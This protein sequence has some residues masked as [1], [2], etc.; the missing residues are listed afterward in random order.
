[1]N[2]PQ[3]TA[4][5]RGAIEALIRQGLNRSR[6]AEKVGVHRSTMSREINERSS[7]EGYRAGFAQEH[8][9]RERA[10][11][12]QEKKM[13]QPKRQA[14]VTSKLQEGWS[15]EQI[16]GRI[17]LEGRTDLYVCKETIYVWLFSDE[18]AYE[19]EKFYQYLRLGRKKRKQQWGRGRHRSKIPNRVSIHERPPIVAERI[20]FGHFEGDSVIYPHKYA[21]NTLNELLTGLVIFTKLRQ[22][23]AALTAQA[24]SQR[25]DFWQAKTVTLDNGSEFTQHEQVTAQ[26]GVKVYFADPYSS[27]QRGANE[28][29]NMLLR[30]YLP[31]RQKIGRLTQS[32]LDDIAYDLNHRPRKRHGFRSPFEVYHLLSQS[33]ANV[34]LDSGM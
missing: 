23:T 21:I 3:L 2:K 6:I 10:K 12:K 33:K 8:Y 24:L 16:A 25:L 34:A 29:V 14:Y 30:G 26:T 27:W 17:R 18:W 15:P 20:E 5:Q 19:W 32:D 31:K 7:P 11:C 9:E 28:N 1:M 4:S 13:N 22:K